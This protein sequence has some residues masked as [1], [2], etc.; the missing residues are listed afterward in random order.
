MEPPSA[1]AVYPPFLPEKRLG[2]VRWE[3]G[4]GWVVVVGGGG[5]P[6]KGALRML[7]GYLSPPQAGPGRGEEVATHL[8]Q[9]EQPVPAGQALGLLGAARD[10]HGPAA[11][12]DAR[13]AGGSTAEQQ[14]QHPD[15]HF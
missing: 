2:K 9:V 11:Q 7:R 14:Q 12:V 8:A 1:E 4:K 10:A 5:F 13:G 3:E 6:C 15:A